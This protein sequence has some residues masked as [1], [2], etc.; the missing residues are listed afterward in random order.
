MPDPIGARLS[1]TTCWARTAKCIH[2]N[3]T[4]QE[5]R[6]NIG[7][8]RTIYIRCIYGIFGRKTTKYTVIYGACIRFWPTLVKIIYN[9]PCF[10]ALI[11]WVHP[12]ACIIWVH[13]TACII[14]VHP[15]ACIIYRT[16]HEQMSA[17]AAVLRQYTHTVENVRS[18]LLVQENLSSSF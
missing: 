10:F 15:T 18:I 2:W 13:R 11:C 8:A 16:V 9:F 12:T 7:L 3:I 6:F 5:G 1:Q 14:W 17:R 4:Q